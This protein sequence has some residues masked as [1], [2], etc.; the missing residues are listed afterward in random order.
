MQPGESMIEACQPPW[1]D[2]R[3]LCSSW[4]LNNTRKKRE[5]NLEKKNSHG[6]PATLLM[7]GFTALE[8]S[9]FTSNWIRTITT[10][11][12]FLYQYDEKNKRKEENIR[13]VLGLAMAKP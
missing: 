12:Q 4:L 5:G 13:V 8:N 2:L 3:K 7:A 9:A 1:S 10:S 6:Q 11:W